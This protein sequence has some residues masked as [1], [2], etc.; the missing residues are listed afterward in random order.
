MATRDP[1]GGMIDLL[2]SPKRLRGRAGTF[3]TLLGVV[4]LV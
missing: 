4:R 1:A 2:F 3:A